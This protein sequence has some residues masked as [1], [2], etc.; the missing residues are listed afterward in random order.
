MWSG[1]LGV[2][3]DWEICDSDTQ[4][5]WPEFPTLERWGPRGSRPD[6]GATRDSISVL[7]RHQ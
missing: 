7:I 6:L 1:F 5:W 4:V 3:S 2:L